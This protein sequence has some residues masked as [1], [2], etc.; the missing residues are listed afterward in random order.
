VGANKSGT[1]GAHRSSSQP[2]LPVV[3]AGECAHVLILEPDETAALLASPAARGVCTV[4]VVKAAKPVALDPLVE[5]EAQVGAPQLARDVGN[6]H[7]LLP[8]RRLP[9]A[10]PA[11]L[12][13]CHVLQVPQV[14]GQSME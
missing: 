7:Q 1:G 8:R 6:Q 13:V 2:T 5:K 14:R 11:C 9:R 3:L 12:A 4:L 10:S